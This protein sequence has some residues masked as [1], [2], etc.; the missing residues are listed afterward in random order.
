MNYIRKLYYS[1]PQWSSTLSGITWN[2]FCFALL[3]QEFAK[4]NAPKEEEH[5]SFTT[6][7]ATSL[8]R[9][10]TRLSSIIPGFLDDEE[11]EEEEKVQW[12]YSDYMEGLER[13][14]QL[15]NGDDR[16]SSL[17]SSKHQMNL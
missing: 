10:S 5:S 1:T 15:L 6:G 8:R 13:E 14:S 17:M 4:Q 3:L 11:E 7:S 16:A 2:P 12:K 9:M